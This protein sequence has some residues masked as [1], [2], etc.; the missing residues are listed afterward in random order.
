MQANRLWQINTRKE[1]I[2]I[3]L[4]QRALNSKKARSQ[5]ALKY[6]AALTSDVDQG[7]N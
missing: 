1:E 7:W 3:E 6:Q 5:T 2:M 4:M